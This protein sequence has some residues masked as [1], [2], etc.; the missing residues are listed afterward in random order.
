M[1][2][3]INGRETEPEN[4]GTVLLRPHHLLC[5]QTFR[6]KGYSPDFVRKMTE[7]HAL[8]HAEPPAAIRLISGSDLL[9]G[10][11]PNCEGGKCT[12]EKPDRFDA[13]V[14]EYTGLSAGSL[15]AEGI[16]TPGIPAVTEAILDACC[17]GC[18]WLSLCKEIC[19][20]EEDRN[21]QQGTARRTQC[22]GRWS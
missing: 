6:G 12:S 5:L 9:C 15:L 21:L 8:V 3:E 10:S 13:R 17:P 4:K 20:S 16:F 11:C 18:Q 1:T 14:L 7:I 22:R 2:E 19:R